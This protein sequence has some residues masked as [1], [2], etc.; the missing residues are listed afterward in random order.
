MRYV[1]PRTRDA[2]GA[3]YLYG[4]S[5]QN[6]GAGPFTIAAPSSPGPFPQ[7][8]AYVGAVAVVLN[9]PDLSAFGGTRA[10]LFAIRNNGSA[11]ATHPASP[12]YVC[13]PVRPCSSGVQPVYE[14]VIADAR[15]GA[16]EEPAGR[17][18]KGL[19]L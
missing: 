1:N 4:S 13:Q 15:E 19:A 8:W 5:L 12:K 6:T 10:Y 2:N 3:A 11:A 17:A 9:L 7:W 16:V 14:V 18:D